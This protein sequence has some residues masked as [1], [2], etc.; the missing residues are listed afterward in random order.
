MKRYVTLL[1]LLVVLLTGETSAETFVQWNAEQRT[2]LWM[3]VNRAEVQRLIPAA[4]EIAPVP[5][6]ASK[7][8]NFLVGFLDQLLV[9]DGQEK[10][11]GG[12]TGRGVVFGTPARNKETGEAGFFVTRIF[13]GGG[14]NTPPGA[15]KN[16]LPASVRLGRTQQGIDAM[17][18]TT[19]ESW[20]VK[21]TTGGSIELKLQYQGGPPLR[22]KAEL[23]VYSAVEP[24]FFRIYRND[25]GLD[26]V[27]S[28]PGGIDR[29]QSYQLRV[30][31]SELRSL[32]DGHEQL[33]SIVSLP[34]YI[35]HTH[36][37]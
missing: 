24:T 17:A 6:G 30:D 3:I 18:A 27:R 32:F 22:S 2:Y 20:E 35:R 8:A 34:F 19:T 23:K 4:W 31:V 29:V 14:A 26:V 16:T 33:V 12:G 5:T 10:P 15:Y 28:I 37:P 9:L 7:G 25:Q 13:G 21:P 11:L 36:L 1:P